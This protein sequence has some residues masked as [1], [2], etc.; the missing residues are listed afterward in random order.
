M[1]TKLYFYSRIVSLIIILLIGQ[2]S[3]AQLS[4]TGAYLIGNNIE[5]GINNY[6][7]EGAPTLVGSHARSG[8]WDANVFFG[9]VANPQLDG[10]T[11]YHGDFFTPGTAE[12]GFGIEISGINYS[13]NAAN[14]SLSGQQIMGSLSNYQVSGNC[15]SVD[16]NGTVNNIGVKIVY[17]MV[18][19]NLFYNTKI[20]IT[21]N[22]GATANNIYYYRNLD[23]DNN[24]PINFDFTTNNTIV[25]QPTPSC[26]KALVSATQASPTLSYLGLAA[27]GSNFRVSYGGFSNRNGSDIWN[28]LAGLTGTVSSTNFGDEAISLA[29]KIATLAPGAS[30]TFEFSTILDAS[31]IDEAFSN[32]YEFTVGT[33][34]ADICVPTVN[35]LTICAGT[36]TTLEITGPSVADYIWTWSPTTGLSSSTGSSVTASP[37]VS[38][39]YTV[40]GVPT[41]PCLALTISKVI[42][43]NTLDVALPIIAPITY[44]QGAVTV[45]LTAIIPATPVGSTVNWYTVP[46]GGTASS[47]APTPSSATPGVTNYYVST[48]TPTGCESPRDTLVVT[49]DSLP[50][51][52]V[53]SPT[54]CDGSSAILTA[55]GAATY[56]WDS[57]V[58]LTANPYTVSPT[59]TTTYTVEG[60]TV[61]GCKNTAIATVTISTTLA[62]TVNSPTI[63]A[64]GTAVLTAVGGTTYVWDQGATLGVSTLNPF[65]VTPI[66][67]TTYTVTGTTGSCIGSTTVT[68]VVNPAIT[69]TAGSNGPICAGTTLNLTATTSAV[70]AA[71]YSWTGPTFTSGIQ[72]P[73]IASAATAASGAYIV[74]VLVSG[75]SA[76][77][78]VN[79]VVNPIPTTTAASNGPICEGSTLNLTATNFTGATYSWAGPSF[80]S[81][82]Q[83]PTIAGAIVAAS[84][85]YTVTI[86]ANSCSSTSIVNVIVNA[87]P[88]TSAGSNSPIC[89]G[90]TLNLTAITSSGSTY[91]WAGPAFTSAVQNPSITGTTITSSGA[92]IVTVTANGCSSTS[93]VNVTVNSIP[94]TIASSNSPICVGDN[95]NL[96]ATTV[97]GSSYSWTGPSSFNSAAQNP[98]ISSAS[99]ANAGSYIVTI[100][101][102][103]SGCFSSSSVTVVIINPVLPIFSVVNPFCEGD[104]PPI[105][106][107]SS[108]NGITGFWSPIPVSTTVIGNSTY[109][110]N[111]DPGQ[112]ALP[113]SMIITINPLP[114]VVTSPRDTCAPYKVDLTDPTVTAGTTSGTILTYWMNSACTST[115]SSASSIETSGTYFIKAITVEG[116]V[117]VKPVVVDIHSQPLASFIPSPSTVSNLDAY[118][119]MINNSVD[120]I[121]YSWD[122]GDGESSFLT[123][124]DHYFPGLDSGTYIITLTVTSDEGCVDQ[125]VSSVK[126]TE[127][128]IYYIPNTFT[129]DD[130]S[131]NQ[132]FKP[133]FTSGFDH[134]NYKMLI[135]NRWGETVFESNDSDIGWSGLYGVDGTK[136][137]DGTYTW[138]I[139][140]SI[141][142]TDQRKSI[143][144]NV[145]L[146]R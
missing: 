76:T 44:C 28:A 9:F 129:P 59:V 145:N 101:D 86:T 117:D 121:S 115:L 92:Y 103:I 61:A 6:G 3:R 104:I 31:Q 66:V 70:G 24:Q 88:T 72:N 41:N 97:A 58:S 69:V 111:A 39:V 38:T 116:C 47:I 106:P 48:T 120:G 60:T 136:V 68:V 109:N 62:I 108:Q 11:N 105:L 100:T 128:L 142:S 95:L 23:P 36:P 143:T 46:V 13:N 73:S 35:E 113:T 27:I 93:T 1:E 83:N 102:N 45:P 15:I 91:S 131:F 140:F 75:C 77:S 53:N 144:G 32:L 4:S 26:P 25:A 37:M 119:Q 7:F 57:N 139:E 71:T 19:T 94:G 81:A 126:V 138:K 110:F 79:V 122:F 10:W 51:I 125:A 107:G 14:S 22:T 17:H 123:N 42:N 2:N 65:S 54:I 127:E 124:P 137:Q 112:C 63:C 56:V 12:N 132:S 33:A 90:S 141:K 96:A 78:T 29:Y 67:T 20:T 146:I 74:T 133:I 8:Q 43:V 49:I 99:L 87:I 34:P 84:G 130:D 114:V 30:E 89:S 16:W 64:G 55:A 5:V 52:T 18:T 82:V 98:T 40:T 80:T 85:S 135:F 118:S 21:N 50:V 134:Y